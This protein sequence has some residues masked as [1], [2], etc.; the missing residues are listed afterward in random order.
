MDDTAAF[1][2]ATAMD[3]ETPRA[4]RCASFQ[5]T[6]KEIAEAASK[7]FG[8]PFALVK[9][10]TLAELK[11]RNE[12][13]RAANPEGEHEVFPPWQRMQYTYCMFA[14]RHASIEN[15]RYPDVTWTP[16]NELLKRLG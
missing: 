10:G 14:T 16:V 3:P 12:A 5:V 2:A 9:L 8:A 15:D 13:M 7:V 11:Q 1:T 4:L 6:P